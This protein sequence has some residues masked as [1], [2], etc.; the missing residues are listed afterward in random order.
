M[1]LKIYVKNIYHKPRAFGALV[2]HELGY[3]PELYP[4]VNTR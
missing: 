1:A 3:Q 2:H 4:K